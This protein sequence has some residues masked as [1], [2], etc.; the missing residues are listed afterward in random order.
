MITNK[1]MNIILNQIHQLN[2][3]TFPNVLSS[4]LDSGFTKKNGCYFLNYFLA[5]SSSIDLTSFEDEISA[6]CFINSFH[7]DDYI[8]ENY[9]ENAILFCNELIFRW[10]NVY[11]HNI[12][13]MIILDDE[14]ILPVIKFHSLRNDKYWLNQDNLDSYSEP[15]LC[16]T[17]IIDI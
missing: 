3:D 15:I 1:K 2:R 8:S 17:N 4:I 14:Y 5:L 16:T 7:I 9:L 12:N 11:N 10:K 13:V 6:E